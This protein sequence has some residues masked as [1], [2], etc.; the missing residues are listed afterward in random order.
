ML[1]RSIKLNNF[2]QFKDECTIKFSLDKEKNVTVIMGENG[3]G[4]T[5]LEQAFIWCLYDKNS[6]A[7]KELINREARDEMVNGNELS[8]YVELEITHNK[9]D[10]KIYRKQR[11]SK[12]NDIVKKEK[13]ENFF[14]YERD[15][16]GDYKIL[17][18]IRA[19]SIV[20]EFLPVDLA[21]FFF[22]DGERLSL[23]SDELL[24]Q[25]NSS[26]FRDAVRGLVGLSAM[27]N[28]I[29]HLGNARKKS[30]VIGKFDA[31]IDDSANDNVKDKTKR[32]E[33]LSAE[34]DNDTAELLKIE[35]EIE[36]YENDIIKYSKELSDMQDAIN[37]KQQYDK[38]RM[39]IEKEEK[40]KLQDTKD[41]FKYFAK[42]LGDY[43]S[44]PLLRQALE[45]VKS[46]DKLDKG[47]PYMHADTITFILKRGRCVCGTKITK[48]SEIEKH[49]NDLILTLPP[50]S[51]GNMIAQFTN[52]A[53]ARMRSVED[54]YSRI[55]KDITTTMQH[56][57]NIEKMKIGNEN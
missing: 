9:K 51:L 43:F 55:N 38:C 29:A 28:A 17:D 24:T 47:I 42:N 16:N 21:K 2:R 10:Y 23:M 37:N 20:Q 45:E 5:T 27:L 3:S 14:V 19:M 54:F 40:E 34:V 8:V 48:H 46:A 12:K 26:N 39:E 11:Y 25:G 52:Q 53:K 6:F 32:I 30:T 1:I 33:K 50:N 18:Q 22:F 35:T 57:S 15:D 36:K 41:L 44:I 7:I 56:Q 31:E 49:L 4:K 13:L